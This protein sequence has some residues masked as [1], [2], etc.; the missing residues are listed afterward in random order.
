MLL[1]A[2]GAALNA[3]VAALDDVT[4]SSFVP[5]VAR[6]VPVHDVPATSA[7][8]E[9]DGSG[10]H[11][12]AVTHRDWSGELREGVRPLRAVTEVDLDPLQAWSLL[13]QPH[14]L[15]RAERRHGCDS[16]QRARPDLKTG[17]QPFDAVVAGLEGVLAEHGSLRL[18]VQLE[19]HPIDG[20]VALALLGALDEC[21]PQSRARRLR[22]CDHGVVDVFVARGPLDLTTPLQQVEE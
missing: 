2:A 14:N 3:R 20:E 15:A 18:V 8:P 6:E 7:E 5:V 22:R 12:D 21:A 4:G 10:V 11:H 1:G 13:E 16:T 9:L 17:D 19:M